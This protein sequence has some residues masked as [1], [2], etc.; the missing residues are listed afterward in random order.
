MQVHVGAQT[1]PIT[2]DRDRVLLATLLL[3]AG[4]PVPVRMLAEAVWGDH[5]PRDSRNQVQGCISRLRR[6]LADAGA[7]RQAIAT[8]PNGYRIELAPGQLDLHQWREQCKKARAAASGG[9]RTAASERYRTALSLWRGPALAD[10][11]SERI[12][13]AAKVLDEERG[14]A[15][16]ECL[17]IELALGRAVDLVPELRELVRQHP[18][19]ESL[20]AALML[21]LYQAGRQAD[22][23]TAYLDVRARLQEDLG[24]DVGEDLRRLHRAIL[25][26]DPQLVPRARQQLSLADNRSG[27]FQ[28]AAPRTLPP[29]IPNFVGRKEELD[30]VRGLLAAKSRM[31]APVIMISG[32][33]GVGKTAFSIRAAHQVRSHY[34]DGQLYADLRGFD[35]AGLLSPFDVLGRF[36][37]A[38]GVAGASVPATLDERAQLYRGLLSDHKV[39]VVLDNAASEE[40]VTPLLPAYEGC[41]VVINSRSR[42]GSAIGADV[43]NLSV[44]DTSKATSLVAQLV[45]AE[46][47]GAEPEAATQLVQLCGLLPLAIRVAAGRLASKPHWH[48]TKMVERLHDERGRLDHLKHGALDVRA[49]IMLSYTGLSSPAQCLLRGLGD[50]DL[51][52]VTPW[53]AAAVLDVPVPQAEEILEQLFD[54]QLVDI[55][56][57]GSA[58]YVR[59]RQHD[60][61]RLFA[62]ERAEQEDPPETRT[63][64]R[65]RALAS[66]LS[67]AEAVHRKLFGGDYENVHSPAP[68]WT[69]DQESLASICAD[70]IRW[71]D[72]EHDSIIAMVRRAAREGL[73]ALSWGLA[74]TASRLIEVCGNYDGWSD[75]LEEVHAA[76]RAHGDR[77]GEAVIEYRLGHLNADLHRNG[78]ARDHLHR[79]AALYDQVG[80]QHGSALATAYA[81]M[82]ERREGNHDAALKM[83]LAAIPGLREHK[84]HAGEALALR[85]AG[86]VQME[87]GNGKQADGLFAQ[88][89]EVAR[90]G[91]S[92]RSEA[93]VLFW[94]GMRA[95]KQQHYD[96][97]DNLFREV[98]DLVRAVG[99][100]FGEAQAIRG[101]GLCQQGQGHRASAKSSLLEALRLIR[102]PSPTVIEA[103]IQKDLSELDAPE[104]HGDQPTRGIQ[105]QA[106]HA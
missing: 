21:A 80:N 82:I 85:A 61:V 26:H 20:H 47:V 48:V 94:Q 81:G 54:A 5:L 9:D 52:E 32:P 91:N 27:G 101:I 103:R 100:R 75:V 7:S 78:T 34:P 93:Q 25:S 51:P 59:Y 19:Q 63:S 56:D 86:Q 72:T 37:R 58:G 10:I 68:R 18:Y 98:L 38:L 71:F 69:P 92:T 76:T 74:S 42:F 89:L 50:V 12:R 31:T 39:L 65:R 44:L 15:L 49:S 60:L 43:V 95:L 14:R 106:R 41:G 46:R 77:L 53:V 96:A 4:N 13:S 24:V 30:R 8:D 2:A 84:D 90:A 17:E 45:G 55:A 88:A 105:Q 40:Q 28:P 33:A 57:H 22:A 11:D 6:Q 79:A 35:P 64:A 87:M 73:T 16:E 70:P 67:A 99:D 29:D 102:Q 1:I 83:A 97:A 62:A 104:L 3:D 23:L 36:L 66:W